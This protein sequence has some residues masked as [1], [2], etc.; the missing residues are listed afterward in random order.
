[1][2]LHLTLA[3]VGALPVAACSSDPKPDFEQTQAAVLAHARCIDEAVKASDVSSGTVEEQAQRV[4]QEC[5]R[6]RV[7]ALSLK[8]VPVF[9]AT[10]EQYDELQGSLA[11][12][13]IAEKRNERVK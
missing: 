12:G 7:R 6:K 1:V 8:A 9:E 10:V 4:Q 3:I 13:L 11:V 5:S 2:R